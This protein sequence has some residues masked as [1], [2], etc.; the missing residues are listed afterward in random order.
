MHICSL[1]Q[2]L[3]NYQSVRTGIKQFLAQT[4]LIS[5]KRIEKTAYPYDYH[6]IETLKKQC[7]PYT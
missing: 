5:F 2:V 3:G 4:L 7:H 6:I 1:N